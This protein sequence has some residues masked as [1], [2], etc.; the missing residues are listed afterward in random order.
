MPRHDQVGTD[1]LTAGGGETSQQRHRNG[2]RRIGNDPKWLARQTNVSTVGPHDRN[3][4]PGESASEVFRSKWVEFEG[5]DSCAVSNQVARDRATPGA[6]VEN[7]IVTSDVG[8]VN[9][10]F[11]P[12]TV[13]SVPSPA[14][15]L[16]GHGRPS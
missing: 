1:E 16:L 12:L 10:P 15:P 5:D 6:D 7:E 11:G 3:A 2:E 8:V 9:E 13:E 4:V 14:C